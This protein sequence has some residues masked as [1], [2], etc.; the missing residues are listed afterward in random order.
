MKS[1]VTTMRDYRVPIVI[2]PC[3]EGGYYAAC[4]TLPGCASQGETYIEAL[5]NIQ[6]AL[7]GYVESLIAHGDPVPLTLLGERLSFELPLAVT[8]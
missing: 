6:E 4:P 1:G 3:E 5:V 2:E 8:A 7:L